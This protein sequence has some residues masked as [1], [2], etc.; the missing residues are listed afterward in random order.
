MKKFLIAAM[1]S[2]SVTL[3]FTSSGA[4]AHKFVVSPDNFNVPANGAT[5]ISA[6]FT[7]I[8][9][10]PEYSLSLTGMIYSQMDT[11]FE[12]LYKD[13]TDSA[14]LNTA[15][16][17]YDSKTM[18]ETSAEKSDVEYAGF[19]VAKTG[20]AIVNAK[21]R[22]TIDL[23]QF[24]GEGTAESVSHSKTFLNL[25]N[26]GMAARRFGGDDVLEVVFAQD[27]PS[28]G[29]KVRD[30]I[31]FKFFLK[32]E[33]LRN[34]PVFASY[35]GAPLYTIKEGEDDVPVNDYLEATT[36][37]NG[38]ATFKPD[39]AAPWFVGAFSG[40]GGSEEYGGGILF[41]VRENP[42]LPGGMSI[43]EEII[44]TGANGAGL[45]FGIVPV[46][47]DLIKSVYGYAW[48]DTFVSSPSGKTGFVTGREGQIP[49]NTGAELVIPFDLTSASFK[50]LTGV[51]QIAILTP[52]T[53]GEDTYN[54][55]AD[56]IIGKISQNSDRIF[57]GEDGADYYYIPYSPDDFLPLFGIS[58][59][60]R[61]S[62]GKILDATESFQMGVLCDEQKIK[63]GEISVVFGTMLADSGADGGSY[64]KEINSDL[65]KMGIPMDPQ[66]SIVYDG[67]KDDKIE[68]S[69]W[70]AKKSESGGSG[71]G[72]CSAGQGALAGLA[73]MAG[74]FC[75][76]RRKRG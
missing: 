53:L 12:V 65:S 8:I 62:D 6:T 56:F 60:C 5:G 73:I 10:V 17:P 59:M 75:A 37:S 35:V 28:G 54:A 42:D 34:A 24:G 72:G 67:I 11:S 18:T 38:I 64:W 4:F 3:V 39:S 44:T 76:S 52:V 20:T 41:Q 15:F 21:F 25:T 43:A 7:E 48:A 33:P 69:Y 49:G 26:D 19:S 57:P 47:T 70:L 63:G 31:E 74:T 27:A 45:D 23:S 13:G 58:I 1:L 36:D 16:K 22:G 71:G 29:V 32:G 68:F 40:E 30:K 9:G 46:F 61:F 2:L 66:I 55:L 50:G 14:I 51:E